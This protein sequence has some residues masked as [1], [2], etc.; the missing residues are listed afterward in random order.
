MAERMAEKVKNVVSSVADRVVHITTDSEESAPPQP[1][2]TLHHTM[3][4]LKM[5]GQ[6]KGLFDLDEPK[7]EDDDKVQEPG[8]DVLGRYAVR[9]ENARHADC[10]FGAKWHGVYPRKITP[11]ACA[12]F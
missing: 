6:E 11:S 1:S 9:E 3:R 8:R 4:G 12:D 2:R 10:R 7:W 5:V